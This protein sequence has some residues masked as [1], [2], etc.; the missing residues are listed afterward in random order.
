MLLAAFLDL[1]VPDEQVLE[2]LRAA[3]P[4][5]SWEIRPVQ[6]RAIRCLQRVVEARE[7]D[8][9]HRHLDEIETLLAAAPFSESVRDQGLRVS[10]RA[11]ENEH[12]AP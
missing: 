9:P 6:R 3:L 2:P 4:A 7:V 1:G 8:P 5:F 10:R 12:L 11:L